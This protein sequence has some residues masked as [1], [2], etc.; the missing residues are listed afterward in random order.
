MCPSLNS[1]VAFQQPGGAY[2][3]LQQPPNQGAYMTLSQPPNIQHP[4]HAGSYATLQQP[5]NLG[6]YVTLQQPP[7]QQP[8][9]SGGAYVALQQ[10]PSNPG[11]AYVTLQQAPN[12]YTLQ[13]PIAAGA[14][15]TLQ[16]APN[17]GY[18][19]LQQSPNPGFAYVTLRQ[20]PLTGAYSTLQHQ[21]VPQPNAT[22]AYTTLQQVPSGG[23][24]TTLQPGGVP[25]YAILQPTPQIG[26]LPLQQVPGTGGAYVT[27]Q[28]Q[29]PNGAYAVPSQQMPNTVPYTLLQ[30][31]HNTGGAYVA[32][33]GPG[34]VSYATL[35]QP[36]NPISTYPGPQQVP[37]QGGSTAVQAPYTVTYASAQQDPNQGARVTPR[38]Q[39]PSDENVGLTLGGGYTVPSSAP[40][41]DISYSAFRRSVAESDPDL[42]ARRMKMYSVAS[43]P[44]SRGDSGQSISTGESSES[45]SS[46]SEEEEHEE[47]FTEWNKIFQD[48]LTEED[49]TLKY[50]KLS[51]LASD[52]VTVAE[53]YGRII[54]S[55]YFVPDSR[56]SISPAGV[57]G[58]A[59]GRK[60]AC[61]GILFKFSLDME[62]T[63]GSWMYGGRQ[64]LDEKAMKAACNEKKGLMSYW[65]TDTEGLHYPLMCLIHFRGFVLIAV[66]F[67]PLEKGSL[68]YG[69]NDAGNTVF[70]SDPKL[71]LK[72][73]KAGTKMNLRGHKVKNEILYAPGDIEGHI[74]QDGR[75]YVLDFGRV[76]PPEAP[77]RNNPNAL[78][79][80]L[81]RPEFVR[82]FPTRLC[83]DAFSGWLASE[84]S[85]T[86]HEINSD[87][88]S[89]TR[90]LFEKVIPDFA[91]WADTGD[92]WKLLRTSSKL[93]SEVHRRGINLRHLGKIRHL[94][95]NT[96]IQRILLT[97]IVSRTLK[98]CLR[99]KLREKMK[100]LKVSIQ[101]PYL[102]VVRSFL[103]D[104]IR[105]P[106][107]VPSSLVVPPLDHEWR[108]SRV[109][110]LGREIPLSSPEPNPNIF[111]EIPRVR[112][113]GDHSEGT[114]AD[115][116]SYAHESNHKEA[117]S[118]SSSDEWEEP[119]AHH[120]A[121]FYARNS[122]EEDLA[123][124]SAIVGS[125]TKTE[126]WEQQVIQKFP[127]CDLQ[128]I[129]TA[130][131]Q[132]VW[133]NS[134]LATT[135]SHSDYFEV[136]LM[137]GDRI[138]F[139]LAFAPT[140]DDTL[141]DGNPNYFLNSDYMFR[142]LVFS[143]TGSLFGPDEFVQ[144]GNHLFPVVS[145]GDTIGLL[146]YE[147]TAAVVINGELK[148]TISLDPF[149]QG[150][151]VWT[152]PFFVIGGNTEI[153]VNFGNKPFVA[154]AENL[155]QDL[156]IPVF[157]TSQSDESL[158]WTQTVKIEL[159]KRFPDSLTDHELSSQFNL[160]TKICLT[161]MISDLESQAGIRF[162]ACFHDMI[163][164]GEAVQISKYH[165]EDL[166]SRVSY[167]DIIDLSEA[168]SISLSVSEKRY[169]SRLEEK[170][171]LE[172]ARKHIE[173]AAMSES[174]PRAA[175]YSLWCQI[176]LQIAEREIDTNAS[177]RI[178]REV[179]E[180]GQIYEQLEETMNPKDVCSTMLPFFLALGQT[181]CAED[182]S[183]EDAK[184][185]YYQ[186]AREYFR[187][188]IDNP[189][190]PKVRKYVALLR[191]INSE[192]SQMSS[193][194]EL[195]K[196]YLLAKAMDTTNLPE[197]KYFVLLITTK[198]Y[199]CL[200]EGICESSGYDTMPKSVRVEGY[201]E[202]LLNIEHVR[203]ECLLNWAH[204]HENQPED[205]ERALRDLL[206]YAVILAKIAVD[207]EEPTLKEQIV[208][209]L[210]KNVD[211]F[212]GLTP[213]PEKLHL[214]LE[215]EFE[216]LVFRN[217]FIG[218]ARFV[219][220]I[221]TAV[222]HF[223]DLEKGES[224]E[225]ATKWIRQNLE[226][227][228][229]SVPLKYLNKKVWE[230]I[231]GADR[232]QWEAADIKN[233]IEWKA[234]Q[235]DSHE[236]VKFEE[237]ELKLLSKFPLDLLSVQ[238]Y[239]ASVAAEY[240]HVIEQLKSVV[241]D[242]PKLS[243][244][245]VNLQK[246]SLFQCLGSDGKWYTSMCSWI[247]S[248]AEPLIRVSF[249]GRASKFDEIFDLRD[250]A[251]V[252]R[253]APFMKDEILYGM[254]YRRGLAAIPKI[255]SCVELLFEDLYFEETGT[256]RP[257]G[258]KPVE[259]SK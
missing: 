183:S 23:A 107:K 171:F 248:E 105:L 79:Y 2:V 243:K 101:E 120:D 31:P 30:Q 191:K 83:S 195:E 80:N 82:K 114:S 102:D 13:Q 60:Y 238:D 12:T 156:G 227:I 93:V 94:S 240:P 48:L 139:G 244:Y 95:Q 18:A 228:Y 221:V 232:S 212:S 213:Q 119:E 224:V 252:K 55:E 215:L 20:D 58:I 87:A 59:G 142:F 109:I 106:K 40:N 50:A 138:Y 234:L 203:E 54:I 251:F 98:N 229:S 208:S 99:L 25:G 21:A 104:I 179:A 204:I 88:E 211:R 130:S 181:K 255:T 65:H 214:F 168:A 202:P 236:E 46:S 84:K 97:E 170:F 146:F 122:T 148:A 5:P 185:S 157:A 14:Y 29:A 81:L 176:L 61:Q 36:L 91:E 155:C 187:M 200:W 145:E 89:A 70:A 219:P 116:Y 90:Y 194:V 127:G 164:R 38:R 222:A 76:M 11:G 178:Y 190:T 124:F 103:K 249:L 96:R 239:L 159:E 193:L 69:S 15:T 9:N 86:V 242:I 49:S 37:H 111:Y 153:E 19:P 71:N 136:K 177:R 184:Q 217:S 149:T 199:S 131:N 259:E 134:W 118:S 125:E 160:R 34:G 51:A 165:I 92:N 28:N 128:W 205:V 27:L 8:M 53:T 172:K 117:S 154:S 150:K 233:F 174:Y 173:L 24:Y 241:R 113:S 44:Y 42:N 3:A 41:D 56:K 246:D 230:C 223:D 132:V 140:V 7:I 121:Q 35:Q 180:K 33:H 256:T 45:Y 151:E 161:K 129:V 100:V 68:C 135:P 235:F 1:A 32:I 207:W 123:P 73:E 226:K 210:K 72:M 133:A 52:F 163:K 115:S 63:P 17:G 250:L 216:P 182:E 16:Q 197:V 10:P 67:L 26:A 169:T 175:T 152:R 231:F 245:F 85:E 257:R 78:F 144:I 57:G 166:T 162:S 77:N 147:E 126:G 4:S 254:D 192:F 74:G 198:W 66:S 43:P 258:T 6:A 188:F 186:Q 253:I 62:L 237:E 137:K 209:F 189:T 39:E 201:T 196:K 143:A 206:L 112:K 247:K 167:M 22:G 220:T 64:C 218:E 141:K 110:E 75:H 158:F 108:P 225:T 47:L